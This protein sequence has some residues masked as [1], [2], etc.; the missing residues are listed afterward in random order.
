MVEDLPNV[1]IVL[2]KFKDADEFFNPMEYL[3]KYD[4]EKYFQL[5]VNWKR[6]NEEKYLEVN[7]WLNRV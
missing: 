5:L 6:K 1:N 4:N 2:E 7:P 3:E